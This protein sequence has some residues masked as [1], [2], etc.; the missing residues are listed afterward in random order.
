MGRKSITGGVIPSG[1]SRIRL[2]FKF[3][4]VRYRPTLLRIPSETN[5]QW[6]RRHLQGLKQRITNG[7]FSFAEE[8]PEYRH[9]GKVPDQ[10]SPRTCAQVFHAYLTHCASRVLKSDLAPVTLASYRR[11]LDGFWRPR[12]GTDRF[13]EVRYSKLIEIADNVSW[14]KKSYNNAI[15][16]LRRAFKFGYRDHPEK[17]DPT[18]HLKSVRIRKKDRPVID[19]FTI[20]D[21]ETLIAALHRDWGEAQGNYDEFRFFTG[22][23]P[24]SRLRWFT[25]H[26]TP[27]ARL[28]FRL[29]TNS[30]V[31][32]NHRVSRLRLPTANPQ[33]AFSRYR[34][35]STRSANATED[36]RR[37]G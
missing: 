10:G 35:V 31:S 1:N 28:E 23:R 16:I 30:I 11:V 34:S 8:F 29:V 9:L 17:D 7:T 25:Q 4:G 2:D 3:A 36:W 6:A 33:V 37:L 12:I 27:R 24:R 19:P 20:Q 26:P 5:L 32:S 15:S 18:L 14:S 13:L 21:A 22:L